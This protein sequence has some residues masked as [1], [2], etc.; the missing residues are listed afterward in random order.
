MCIFLLKINNMCDAI[1]FY[2]PK[3]IYSIFMLYFHHHC[4]PPGV[5]CLLSRDP[6][7]LVCI[8]KKK[9]PKYYSMMFR[10]RSLL[11]VYKQNNLIFLVTEVDV[12]ADEE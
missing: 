1:L 5:V 9:V 2:F 11:N 6:P 7:V 4:Q 8:Y 3:T 12:E 10:Y